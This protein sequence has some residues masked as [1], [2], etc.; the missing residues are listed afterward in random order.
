MNY[1]KYLPELFEGDV[2]VPIFI[3]IL[4]KS[5]FDEGYEFLVVSDLL[6]H[7]ELQYLKH[8]LRPNNF[9][10]SL[11]LKPR[12]TSINIKQ[13]PELTFLVLMK[14]HIQNFDEQIKINLVVM[15]PGAFLQDFPKHGVVLFHGLQV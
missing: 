12:V 9:L 8:I 5:I 15:P 13:K 3:D 2:P 14:A 4:L 7:N 10:P 11:V 6:A 1:S